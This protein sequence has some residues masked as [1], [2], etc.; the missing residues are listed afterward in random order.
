[1]EGN[2]ETQTIITLHT[3]RD[4]KDHA[5]RFHEGTWTKTACTHKHLGMNKR[6]YKKDAGK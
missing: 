3:G 6:K 2:P 5:D 4:G 1:M